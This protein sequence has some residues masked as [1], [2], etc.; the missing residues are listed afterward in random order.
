MDNNNESSFK[1]FGNKNKSKQKNKQ[2]NKNN[3]TSLFMSK[4]FASKL[5]LKLT[6]KIIDPIIVCLQTLKFEPENRR[7]E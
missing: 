6:S 4:T 5:F 3:N 7:K 2:K 1:P